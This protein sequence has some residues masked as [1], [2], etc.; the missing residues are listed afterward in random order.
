MLESA[1]KAY[2]RHFR[3]IS[4]LCFKCIWNAFCIKILLVNKKVTW[5]WFWRNHF[6]CSSW[7]L[8]LFLQGA[9]ARWIQRFH[10]GKQVS[11]LDFTDKETGTCRGWLI[12]SDSPRSPPW[13]KVR[14][15]YFFFFDLH[16]LFTAPYLY[17]LHSERGKRKDKRREWFLHSFLSMPFPL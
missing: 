9:F 16:I 3:F 4:A 10:G 15:H 11:H 8:L 1:E 12:P 7:L 2:V 6:F 5:V 13:V 14:T 17:P